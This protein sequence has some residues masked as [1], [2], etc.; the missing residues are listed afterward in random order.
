MAGSSDPTVIRSI[1]VTTEDLVAAV[2]MNRT[3]PKQAVLR[4]TPPFSGRMRARL[5]VEGEEEYD[6]PRPVHVDPDVLLADD[7]AAYPRP[8]DT[9][10]ELRRDS[11]LSYTVERHHERHTAAVEAWRNELSNTIRSAVSIETPAGPH[12]VSVAILGDSV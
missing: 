1:A 12:E 6:E 3:T 11:S 10:A 9:E 7:A 8:T 4:L 5:H 2:E